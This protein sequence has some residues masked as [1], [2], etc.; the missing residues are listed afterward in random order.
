MRLDGK[1]LELATNK[2]MLSIRTN[3]ISRDL[4][5]KFLKENNILD[6]FKEKYKKSYIESGIKMGDNTFD[7]YFNLLLS[8]P[9]HLYILT[10]FP[11]DKSN[12]KENI[13][14]MDIAV[15]WKD[16]LSKYE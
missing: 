7:T 6:L 11:L 10:A 12:V 9:A 5:I 13:F 2:N 15:K 8:Q 4:F 1:Y 3:D 16:E 14:W